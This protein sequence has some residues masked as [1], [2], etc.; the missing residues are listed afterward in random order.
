MIQLILESEGY[1]VIS[2][3]NGRDAQEKICTEKPDIIVLDVMMPE[4]DGFSFCS[5]LKSNKDYKD[6]PVI[7]LTSVSRHIYHSKYSRNDIMQADIDEYVEK[8]LIPEVLLE[9]I[10]RLLKKEPLDNINR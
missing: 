3:I 1:A 5:W 4:M 6:I 8:P 9:I 10:E 7:L 2:A